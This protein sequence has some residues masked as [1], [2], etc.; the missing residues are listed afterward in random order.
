MKSKGFYLNPSNNYTPPTFHSETR[1]ITEAKDALNDA[2]HVK[3]MF[4]QVSLMRIYYFFPLH[5]EKYL[6]LSCCTGPCGFTDC[7][8]EVDIS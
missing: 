1:H 7:Q 3:L 2:S 8:I 6:D 5:H 4:P